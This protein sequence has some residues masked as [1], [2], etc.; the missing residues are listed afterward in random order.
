VSKFTKLIK[1]P[2]LFLYDALK[3]RLD[4]STQLPKREKYI[5]KDSKE[6]FKELYSF[7]QHYDVNSMKIDNEYIWPYIRNH[8]IS[9]LYE[10][11]L[12]KYKFTTLQPFHLQNGHYSQVSQD[13]RKLL[14]KEYEA[15]ELNELEATSTDFLFFVPMN[16]FGR[17]EINNKVYHRIVDPLFTEANKMG[18]ALKIEVV[19]NSHLPAIKYWH[20][21]AHKS[22]LVLPNELIKSGYS[23]KLQYESN[24]FRFFEKYI[25]SI[26]TPSRELLNEL[27]DFELYTRDFYI[28]LL[29]ILKPK[30]ICFYAYHFNAPLISAAD[31][32]GI[33]TVDLQHGLQVGWGPIYNN[34]GEL[35]ISGYQA[36]PDIFAVW[37]EKEYNHISQHYISHK[38]KAVYM[39]NPWLQTLSTFPDELPEPIVEKLSTPQ[40]KILLILQDQ[41]TIPLLIKNIIAMSSSD[42]LW[43]VRHHPSTKKK[44]T[45]KDFGNK[46]NILINTNIDK[47]R[48]NE[49]FKYTDIAI[50]EGSALTIEA[51][52]YGVENIL[53]GSSGYANYKDE[54]S[55]GLFYFIKN[56]KE[57][58][59]VL[60]TINSKK[61][62]YTKKIFA[63]VSP[64]KML[65]ELLVLSSDLKK[66]NTEI[67]SLVKENPNSI[68]ISSIENIWNILDKHIHNNEIPKALSSFYT[69]RNNL[70]NLQDIQSKYE[71]KI[72][73][74]MKESRLNIKKNKQTYDNISHELIYMIG[75]SL[76]LP[77]KGSET[78]ISKL[79]E[80]DSKRFSIMT[81]GQRYL[82]TN[83]L[84]KYWPYIV[85]DVRDH[86]V[87]IHLGITDCFPRIFT[88]KQYVNL[89]YFKQDVHKE[90][91]LFTKKYNKEILSNQEENSYVS[92][93]EFK[94]NLKN[95]IEKMLPMKPKSITFINIINHPKLNIK[96]IAHFNKVF[97]EINVQ[98]PQVS[99]ID[100]NTVLNAKG[101][102]NYMMPDHIHLNKKGH[103]LLLSKLLKTLKEQ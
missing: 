18:S 92:L 103:K 15:K 26:S 21:Y 65:K 64:H 41:I 55:K 5:V 29:K 56:T 37:G 48:F 73:P 58:N 49:L 87:V 32:L 11:S 93:E 57:F 23:Q 71:Q 2:K 59:E 40:T 28:E 62:Q 1:T 100:F 25:P 76:S 45:K 77:R 50:S 79:I 6:Y 91:M 14:K 67:K 42:I 13:F 16:G 27:I 89:S 10:L 61:T 33:L 38:H 75:D 85:Q 72:D 31:E 35:P 60:K 22:L 24:F 19:K 63:D 43:V 97:E 47:I 101:Y 17:T 96:A 8:L 4:A 95:I 3:K 20:K 68:L 9:N 80:N 84:L 54:I 78:T 7:I 69:L 30:V 46:K 70:E 102:D 34:H 88:E 53:I 52:Y 74:F 90:I 94:L 36:Y 51:S 83:K 99:V 86:H 82:E 44:F 98:F 66:S 39:G 81:W 12:K